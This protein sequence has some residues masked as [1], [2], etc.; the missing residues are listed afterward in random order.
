MRRGVTRT[1]GGLPRHVHVTDTGCSEARWNERSRRDMDGRNE[2]ERGDDDGWP[3]RRPLP[4]DGAGGRPDEHQQADVFA[5]HVVARLDRSTARRVATWAST[6]RCRGICPL[7]LGVAWQENGRL[8][9]KNE[10]L[11]AKNVALHPAGRAASPRE[12][13]DPASRD[14]H[15]LH[16]L[17][18]DTPFQ[19]LTEV[20]P[21]IAWTAR[22]AGWI[23][24]YNQRW[25]DY[26][27][28]TVAR[29]Q[30]WG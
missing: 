8:M 14:L 13:P 7:P 9:G 16:C 18:G 23:D 21:Q 2:W 10:A 28:M 5:G 1:V 17:Q 30:G 24:Y 4:H 19:A 20:I 22:P 27:G 15:C 12:A 29:T 26:T 6:V 3:R 25:C 11:H